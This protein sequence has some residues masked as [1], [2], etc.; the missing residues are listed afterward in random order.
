MER[1]VGI[2][3]AGISGLLACKYVLEM[4][5]NPIVFEAK[6]SVGGLWTH[7]IKTT[8]LQTPKQAF[9]FSD[10]PWPSSVKEDFPDHNQVMEYIESYARHF[11]LLRFIKFNSRVIGI[12]YEGASDEDIVSW[13][14]WGGTGDPFSPRG[15]WNI[16]VEDIDR[17]SNQ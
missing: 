7:T 2:I 9:Q 1:Q 15:K 14:L 12:E 6:P 16:T 4:G 10:F 8:K 13:D 11:N 3:G 5:F 17:K